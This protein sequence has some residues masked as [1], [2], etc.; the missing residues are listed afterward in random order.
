MKSSF[1]PR[2]KE[3]SSSSS[4]AAVAAPSSALVEVVALAIVET[5]V[6]YH[7]AIHLRVG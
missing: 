6:A 7:F 2:K 1:Q 5:L 3:T 4:S